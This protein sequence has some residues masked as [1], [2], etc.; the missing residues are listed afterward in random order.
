MCTLL[1]FILPRVPNSVLRLKFVGCSNVVGQLLER[2]RQQVG[3]SRVGSRPSFP[4]T[5]THQAAVSKAGL[6]LTV[7][8]PTAAFAFDPY[9]SPFLHCSSCCQAAVSKAGLGC[10]AAVLGALDPGH[11][12]SAVA[13]FALLLSF[14]L[15]N[16]PKV[17]K[18]AHQGVVEVLAAV[19]PTPALGH[20]SEAIAKREWGQGGWVGECGGLG[21]FVEVLAAVR[22]TPAL[23]HASPR[24][25]RSEESWPWV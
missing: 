21:A 18:R 11:W 8:A 3:A 20:A 1:G 25:F 15:D 10:L 24:R 14:V 23:G 5:P 6:G 7:P 9:A 19:R 4:P 2:H 16:R 17:R 22:P 13:P 12:P